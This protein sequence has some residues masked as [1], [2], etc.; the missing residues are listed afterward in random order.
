[1]SAINI[2]KNLSRTAAGKPSVMKKTKAANIKEEY[3]TDT[4]EVNNH[5]MSSLMSL[6][7]LL[8]KKIILMNLTLLKKKMVMISPLTPMMH[9]L[10][11]SL[12]V[13]FPK[14]GSKVVAQW[15]SAKMF[16]FVLLCQL[17]EI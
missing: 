1:M 14:R 16:V 6:Q 11:E 2:Y 17:F 4:Q 5:Q 3:N 7:M 15:F 12:L 8:K 13:M 9:P 10:I